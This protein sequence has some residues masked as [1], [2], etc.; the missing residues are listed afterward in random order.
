MIAT[1]LEFI[2]ILFIS[3]Q[4]VGKNFHAIAS[5]FTFLQDNKWYYLVFAY[6]LFIL[7]FVLSFFL[8]KEL[9][10]FL[11]RTH[12]K[13][14]KIL[15]GIVLVFFVAYI[16]FLLL[17]VAVDGGYQY[18]YCGKSFNEHYRL[19]VKENNPDIC[20]ADE[21]Y[22][23]LEA[24]GTFKGG[25]YCLTPTGKWFE[26]HYHPLIENQYD[27]MIL[28]I[29]NAKASCVSAMASDLSN[30]KICNMIKDHNLT[31][32]QG[33]YSVLPQ[34]NISGCIYDFAVSTND[35]ALCVT[36]KQND[37]FCKW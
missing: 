9:F 7:V 19:A 6:A 27:K 18:D 4:A 10:Q 29:D 34:G 2:G 20:L 23:S 33:F 8:Y 36:V 24:A 3:Y 21:L 12:I 1:G 17:G 22:G 28:D 11:K 30:V 15:R 26:L 5:Q 16:P 35:K 31:Y 32:S 14:F 25:A 37:N 13:I